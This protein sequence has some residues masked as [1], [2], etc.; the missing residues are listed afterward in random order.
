MGTLFS[1]KLGKDYQISVNNIGLPLNDKG[2]L[3]GINVIGVGPYGKFDG[4]TFLNT[5]GFFLSGYT[6][7][8]LWA[9]GAASLS[10]VNDYLSGTYE[11]GENDPRA[12]LYRVGSQD[13]P[14]DQ[15]WQDWVDAVA[16]GADFYDG[17]GDQVYNPVDLN[18]NGQ[19]EPSEDRPDLIGDETI[20]CV[21]HDSKPAADRVWSTV[22]PQGIE[23]RQ[24]VFAY[25]NVP[26]L[27]NVIFVRYRI[28]NTGIYN[29]KLEN[30]YFGAW[31]DPDIGDPND[32][33]VGVDVPR[34]AGYAYGNQPDAQYGNQVPCFM[35]DLLSGPRAY[36][37]GVTY[38]DLNGN[39]VYDEG[40]IALDTA[41]S[42]RGLILG[43]KE[44]PG[45]MNLPI[46]S[47]LMFVEG[48]PDLKDPV[49]K[50]EARNYCLG[51]NRVGEIPDPCTFAYGE[52]RGGV[53]CET[54]DPRFWFSGDPVTNVGWICI[55]NANLK[56]MANTG[57]FTLWAGNEIEIIAAYL[58]DRGNDGLNSISKARYFSDYTQYIFDTNFD[59]ISSVENDEG[60]RLKYNLFQNYPNPFNSTTAIKY[61]VPQRSNVTLKV[62]DILGNEI[63]T[64]VN[65]EKQTGT[66]EITWYAESLPSGV[67]FYQLRA[68][69]FV[70][71]KKMV[72]MK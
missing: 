30:V 9:N 66:Y 6:L 3:A 55:I 71:T 24:S 8:T 4:K 69:D 46:S 43:I 17:D 65:E 68:K 21:Y 70:E 14:F 39:G 37:D 64:L 58:I 35:I 19:W 5:S 36:I 67:Y 15:S 44:F 2:I 7:N 45:A 32:D 54:V 53:P 25:Q 29:D 61:S 33:V 57:P 26:N 11:Y 10:Y 51:T 13:I 60:Y 59:V 42:H 62:Y 18:G 49:N 63:V 38:I 28:L 20:W 12:Q 48:D 16:L 34:N 1:Q 41:Y 22:E 72:L 50:N 40:E 56:Q 31:S 23:I 47:S 52:V 27:A